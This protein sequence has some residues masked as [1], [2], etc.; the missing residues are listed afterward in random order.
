MEFSTGTVEDFDAKDKVP[1]IVDERGSVFP[2][3]APNRNT[4]DVM[5]FN[6]VG[7]AGAKTNFSPPRAEGDPNVGVLTGVVEG[8]VEFT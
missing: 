7:V 3:K 1:P 5:G 8:V 6:T 2:L 4:S